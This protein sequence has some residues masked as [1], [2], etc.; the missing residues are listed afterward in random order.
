[1]NGGLGNVKIQSLCELWDFVNLRIP[2]HRAF[3]NENQ[4]GR[5]YVSSA[6]RKGLHAAILYGVGHASLSHC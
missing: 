2:T 6:K 4:R 1:M 5:I 3:K